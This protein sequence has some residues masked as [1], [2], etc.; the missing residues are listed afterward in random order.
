[1][2]Q[3]ANS[4]SSHVRG[5]WAAR[6][7]G[8]INLASMSMNSINVA[9]LS[10]NFLFSLRSLTVLMALIRYPLLSMNDENKSNAALRRCIDRQPVTSDLFTGKC[11]VEEW[12]LSAQGRQSYRRAKQG[13]VA[14]LSLAI[15]RQHPC[16]G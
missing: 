7:L 10:M 3:S 12:P 13:R 9:S 11:G 8:S 4:F 5:T 1:M 16:K 15:L 2:A 14:K 6:T